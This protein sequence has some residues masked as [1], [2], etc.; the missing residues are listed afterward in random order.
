M[1]LSKI[2]FLLSLSVFAA[3][4]LGGFFGGILDGFGNLGN[5]IGGLVGGAIGNGNGGTGTSPA[6]PAPT[7]GNGGSPPTDTSCNTGPVMCCNSVGS[8]N[9]QAVAILMSL[10]GIDLSGV[11]VNVGV[12]CSPVGVSLLQC[13][14]SW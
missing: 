2:T 9:E 14:K 13:L 8:S 5:L 10:L 6:T 3:A 1:L 4:Q 7:P 11:D 12:N